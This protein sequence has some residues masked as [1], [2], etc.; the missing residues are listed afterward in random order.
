M[1]DASTICL[2]N[3]IDLLPYVDFAV[4]RCREY[5]LRVNHRLIFFEIS[6]R[7]GQGMAGWLG[8]LRN[9]LAAL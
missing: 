2:I 8:W 3:K 4:D 7:T 6:A 9:R 1:F 5:A